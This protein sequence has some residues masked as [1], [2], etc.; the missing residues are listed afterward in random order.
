[1]A[2]AR[3]LHRAR[4]AGRGSRRFGFF[5]A[6]AVIHFGLTVHFT[7]H[8]AVLHSTILHGATLHTVSARLV[9]H[10][11]GAVLHGATLHSAGAGTALHGT[12]AACGRSLSKSRGANAK[13]TNSGGENFDG[14]HNDVGEKQGVRKADCCHLLLRWLILYGEYPRLCCLKINYFLN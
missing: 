5:H 13:G 8:R 14:I 9:V 1:M 2:N 12:G 10:G 7:V 4:A 6:L 11:A 3:V